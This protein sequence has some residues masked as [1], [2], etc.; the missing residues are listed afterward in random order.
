MKEALRLSIALGLIC[1]IASAVLALADIKTRDARHAAELREKSK[2][3]ALVLPAFDNQPLQDTVPSNPEAFAK[4][5]VRF[6]L[7]RQAGRLVGI[8]GEGVSEHGFGGPI[9]V[10]VG[11]EPDGVI[12]AVTVTEARETAGLG[13][14]ATTRKRQKT[15]A[16]ILHPQP[17]ASQPKLPPCKYLDQYSGKKVRADKPFK[18]AKDGG[19][20][21]AVTGATISSRA[22]AEAVSAVAEEFARRQRQILQLGDAK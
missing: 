15:L 9:R 11:L 16:D 18:V 22:V 10:L 2:A 6:Y 14:L 13:T 7:A 19:D 21:A 5:P 17:A 8:A 1:C 3:L 20:I 4:A 12:R